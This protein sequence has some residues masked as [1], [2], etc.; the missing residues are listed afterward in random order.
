MSLS[1]LDIELTFIRSL[2]CSGF[3]LSGPQ[4][5]QEDRRERIRVAIMKAQVHDKPFPIDGSITYGQ[6]FL[7]AYNR[8]CELRRFD[9]DQNGKTIVPK[10]LQ[11]RST[12][13]YDDFDDEAED[14]ELGLL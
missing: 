12:E 7:M 1:Q 5:S 3:I 13:D 11:K 4:L 9:R 14:A 2:A 10:V 8:P 6:A